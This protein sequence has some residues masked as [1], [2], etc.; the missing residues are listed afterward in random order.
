MK[1]GSKCSMTEKSFT[2]RRRNR[3]FICW[4]LLYITDWRSLHLWLA[5]TNHKERVLSVLRYLYPQCISICSLCTNW[6]VSKNRDDQKPLLETPNYHTHSS[7]NDLTALFLSC[8]LWTEAQNRNPIKSMRKLS[9]SISVTI[10]ECV[11]CNHVSLSVTKGSVLMLLS[12]SLC[13]H[14]NKTHSEF[15]QLLF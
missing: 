4:L 15:T 7:G 2:V 9:D 10:S 1:L 5:Q 8:F 6:C 11:L 3:W 14:Q 13:L 12:L